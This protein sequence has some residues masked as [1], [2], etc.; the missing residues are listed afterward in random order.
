M[1]ILDEPTSSLD[2]ASE[3][4][5][6]ET[7]EKIAEKTTTLIIAHRI[8]TILNANYVYLLSKGKIIQEG[9]LNDIKKEEGNFK[10]LFQNQI[11]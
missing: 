8:S 3:V 10:K 6:K 4:L 2:S 5:I 1:L 7:L 11:Y 9:T